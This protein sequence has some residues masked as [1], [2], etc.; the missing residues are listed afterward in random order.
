MHALFSLIL[1]TCGLASDTR[2]YAWE[3]Y[4]TL[5]SLAIY[6]YLD[7]DTIVAIHRY[8]VDGI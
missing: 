4:I 2:G 5:V 3:N 6:M 8:V 7:E 1:R